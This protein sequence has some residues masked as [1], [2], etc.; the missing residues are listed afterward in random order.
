MAQR[1]SAQIR[2]W[3]EKA[4]RNASLVVA[5]AAQ[6]VFRDMSERQPSVKETG[7]TYRIGR[8]PVDT[9]L[10]INS[11][12]A[13]L[14]GSATGQGPDAYVAALAGFEGGDSI[15]FAFTQEYAPAIEYGTQHFSGRFMVREAL[16]GGGG[17]QARIDRAAAR[18]QD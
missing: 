1:F 11:M 6:E 5:E 12:T 16:N 2:N 14:N 13:T 17:W 9:G 10:L 3:S 18:F 4:K 15:V 7:G 8:V